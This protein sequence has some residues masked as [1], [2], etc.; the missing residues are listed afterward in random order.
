MGRRTTLLLYSLFFIVTFFL[1]IFVP[2]EYNGRL[3]FFTIIECLIAIIIFIVRKED[4]PIIKEHFFRPSTLFLLGYIIVFFQCYVDLLVGNLTENNSFLFVSPWLINKASLL[5]LGGLI[6]FLVGYILYIPREGFDIRSADSSQYIYP[7]RIL[8]IV[9]G[10]VSFFF[11][12]FNGA[13]YLSGAYSQMYLENKAGTMAL[14]SEILYLVICMTIIVF[15]CRTCYI[16][17]ISSLWQYVKQFGL[18]FHIC[19]LTYIGL[20]IINGTRGSILVIVVPYFC[21]YFL[22]AKKRV[23][24]VT[25][26]VV[27]LVGAIIFT[28]IGYVRNI[29]Q[30]TSFDYKLSIALQ[31]LNTRRDSILPMTSELGSSVR[32]LHYAM[33]YVPSTHP[34]LYGSIQFRQILSIIPFSSQVT[35]HFLDNNFIYKSSAFFI[36]WLSQGASYTYG[37]G[38]SVVADLYLSFGEPGVILGLFMFG[39]LIRKIELY[40]FYIPIGRIPLFYLI[41]TIFAYGYALIIARSSLLSPLNFFIF[42]TIAVYFYQQLVGKRYNISV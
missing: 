40:I 31:E 23:S 22:A 15:H 36:T 17:D 8:V 18:L 27:L 37:E 26:V 16:Q 14:Y 4:F 30:P 12:Y 2:E 39:M 9:F 41:L 10:L 11:V 5:S 19:L 28:T 21:S 25:F 34:Y 42:T 35:K 7:I 20:T 24:F 29:D 38:T 13:D 6:A 3:L 33:N 32:T 1:Y